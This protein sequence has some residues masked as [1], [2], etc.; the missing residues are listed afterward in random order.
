LDTGRASQLIEA[1][2][3]KPSPKQA[4]VLRQAGIDPAGYDRK[5]AS[6]AIDLVKSGRVEDARNLASTP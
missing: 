2:M 5:R 3:S 6:Q 1:L 4:W